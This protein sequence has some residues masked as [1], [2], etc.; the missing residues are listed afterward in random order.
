MCE[1]KHFWNTLPEIKLTMNNLTNLRKMAVWISILN[2]NFH[3][4]AI[5]E[6]D[7]GRVIAKGIL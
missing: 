6:N 5:L 1:T 3:I 2:L 4:L 7:Q